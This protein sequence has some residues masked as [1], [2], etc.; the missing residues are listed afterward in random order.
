MPRIN[1]TPKCV[2]ITDNIIY[3]SQNHNSELPYFDV[4]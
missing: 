2:I 3:V 1:Q 4:Q